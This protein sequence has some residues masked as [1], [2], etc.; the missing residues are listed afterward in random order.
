M[1]QH[2][3]LRD[4][5]VT[6]ISQRWH[7][8]GVITTNADGDP[9]DSVEEYANEMRQSNTYGS[10]AEIEATSAMFNLRVEV[11]RNKN[12]R[13]RRKPKLSCH[14]TATHA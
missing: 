5:I 3:A 8:Y 6:H 12:A 1:T 13:S 9:Y 2:Q 11:Y 10:L 4:E 14:K 7:Y